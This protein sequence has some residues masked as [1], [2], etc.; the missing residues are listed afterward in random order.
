MPNEDPYWSIPCMTESQSSYLSSL[1][2]VIATLGGPELRGT[3]NCLNSGEVI[4]TEILVCIPQA[5]AKNQDLSD[6]DNVH[7]ITTPCRGQVAQRAYG[8]KL[9]QQNM[10]MQ[11]DDDIALFPQTMQALII[12]L[13]ELG[14]GNVVAPFFLHK[15][16][17]YVTSYSDDWVGA[18]QSI[19]AYLI[20]G[21]PWGLKR[22][23]KISPAGIGY[24]FDRM[25]VGDDPIETDWV[26]GG[27]ALCFKEDLVLD[28]YFPFTGKA[29]S[30]DLIHSVLWR[31]KGAQ[32]WAVPRAQCKTTVAHMPFNLNL[33][34]ADYRAHLHVVRMIDGSAWR[35]RLWFTFYFATKL[36]VHLYRILLGKRVSQA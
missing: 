17:T 22:M 36:V 19:H 35:L 9:A 3:I 16:G 30:E 4:P 31:K 25:R 33:I 12:A 10:V 8:L 7:I 28:A 2:V 5:E 21:A 32:L 1:S 23:G 14:H 11:I 18:L 24:W 29:F 20:C 13:K 27:C 34:F 6:I 15:E 26:P